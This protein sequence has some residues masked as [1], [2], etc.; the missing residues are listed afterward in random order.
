MKTQST[1]AEVVEVSQIENA[2]DALLSAAIQADREPAILVDEGPISLG[3]TLDPI[4]Q[5][6]ESWSRAR[7]GSDEPLRRP[8]SEALRQAVHTLGQRLDEL[9]G[10]ALM[11]AICDR[12]AGRDHPNHGRRLGIVDHRWDRIGEW[13]T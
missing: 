5:K 8:V 6:T 9:G 4:L 11:H 2:L 12:V 7:R 1:N 3:T 13:V 10:F